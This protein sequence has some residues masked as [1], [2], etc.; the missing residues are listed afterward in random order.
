VD[1]VPC[2]FQ[3]DSAE[4]ALETVDVGDRKETAH[5]L[6]EN[7]RNRHFRLDGG[8][9]YLFCL[10]RGGNE[11]HL[12]FVSHPVVID[13]FSLKPL[14]KALSAAYRA[15]I[16]PENLGL[17]QQLLL[18]TET[19]RVGN[20]SY[21]ESLR[22][23]LQLTEKASFDWRPARVESDVAD[24][25]FNITLPETV[26]AHLDEVAKKFGIGLDQLLLFSFHLFLFRV[27]RSEMV[28]TRYCHRIRTGSPD[29]IRFSENQLVF[30]SLLT[31][32]LTVSG[33]LRQAARLYAQALH[34]SDL[35]MRE[36][37]LEP[38]R[39]YPDYRLSNVLF[40]EDVQPY[41]ELYLDG[42]TVTLL[43]SLSHRLQIEDIGIYFDLR[44]T[45]SFH[46]LTRSPQD[47]SSLRMTFDHYLAML[48]HLPE[49]LDQKV[50]N[51]R[52]F[53]EPLRKKA[54]T[55]ADGGALMTPAA[56]VLTQ[57]A[58]VCARMPDAPA[59]RFNE[60]VLS[61]AEMALSAG[62]VAAHLSSFVGGKS[63]V[64]LATKIDSKIRP[65]P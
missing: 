7:L 39:K 24:T 48:Q 49:D 32:G 12:V 34:N 9:P 65:F 25:Y 13:R 56:D 27:T 1:G 63:D 3:S 41:R 4:G 19:S 33:F 50:E 23:W 42:V 57:F 58:D 60:T 44:D 16:L 52:L 35:P 29:Q 5:T 30:K 36:V 59:L 11:S 62:S 8:A 43:P 22:F 31:D 37:I 17:P 21:D 18:E 54:L 51:I 10:L 6:I 47:T 64:L 15:E 28:L 26:S 46:A 61:Y 45:I 55:L 40:D 14:F 2:I 20:V 53:N 38:K